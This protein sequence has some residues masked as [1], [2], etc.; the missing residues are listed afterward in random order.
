[1]EHC[2]HPKQEV[3]VS[4]SRKT[5]FY[6]SLLGLSFALSGCSQSVP[7]GSVGIWHN[8][9]T[10][11]ISKKVAHPGFHITLIDGIIPVDTTQTMAEVQNMHPRDEHGVQM[12]DVAVVVQYSLIPNRV[13]LFYRETKQIEN[14]PH[15][16][17]YTLGLRM[18]ERSAIPYSV[19]IA[20]ESSTPQHIAAHLDTYAQRIQTVLNNRLHK[21]YPRIDPYI[22]D[23]VTVP[24]FDLPTSIQKQ[25]NAKAGFQAELETIQAA[26]KVQVQKKKLAALKAEVQADALAD[27]ARASGL[28]PKNII[29]WEKARALYALSHGATGPVNRVVMTKN[30]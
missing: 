27:A 4:F 28:T 3:I 2:C 18:L 24:T 16:D 14:E 26:E 10:G 5:I 19:Q 12:K 23:S 15:T 20:T 17:Y 21:L 13:P 25:V 22:I 30:G 6:T 7:T 8:R 1:M 9:F 29:A 11:Y